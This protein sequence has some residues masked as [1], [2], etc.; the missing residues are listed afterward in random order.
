MISHFRYN[1]PLCEE[2][3]C[4]PDGV[5][6]TFFADGGCA[7]VAP[8]TLCTCKERVE[9]RICDTCKPLFWNLEGNNPLGCSGKKFDWLCLIETNFLLILLDMSICKSINVIRLL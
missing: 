4:N 6:P 3:N 8:G 9:G 7:N 2:C 5:P 1:Y